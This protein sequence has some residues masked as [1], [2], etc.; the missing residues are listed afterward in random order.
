[1]HPAAYSKVFIDIFA[2]SDTCT[3]ID[4]QSEGIGNH[5]A[6][7]LFHVHA[8]LIQKKRPKALFQKNSVWPITQQA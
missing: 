1:M 2:N 4:Y 3:E 6:I 5:L 7:L 8:G